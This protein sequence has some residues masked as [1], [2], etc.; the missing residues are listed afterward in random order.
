MGTTTALMQVLSII[1]QEH[2]RWENLI[3]VVSALDGVTDMLLEAAH[4]AQL[5]NRRGYRRIVATLRTRHLALVENLPLANSESGALQ[6][7]IDRLLFDMLD[8]CQTMSD[9]P[10]TSHAAIDQIIGVGERLAARI[11]AVLLRSSNLRGVAVDATDLIITDSVFGNATPSINLTRQRI[12]ENLLPMLTRDIIP[13]VTGF[14]G[15]TEGGQPTTLGRGGSDYTA[16]IIAV[17]VDA[18]EVWMWTDVDGMMSTDPQEI[19]EA[20]TIPELSYDEVAEQA[21]FGARILHARM[22]GP[23][24]E[25][26]VP[27]WV[28]NIFKPRDPGTLIHHIDSDQEHSIKAVATIHG[29]SL[30]SAYSGPLTEIIRLTDEA[31]FT[32][33]GNHAE[34]MISAQSSDRSF[35]C[36]VIPTSAGPEAV[37]TTRSELERRL[38]SRE[39]KT[40]WTVQPVVIIT[41]IGTHI[42]RQSHLT[43][44]IFDVLSGIQ[45]LGLAQGPSNCSLSFV[46]KIE[47]ND[48]ALHRIHNLVINSAGDTD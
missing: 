47:N 33:T 12:K 14:I 7:E 45:I 35:L 16:S 9:Y 41:V 23:L 36:F 1:L 15:A 31:L 19:S 26:R 22:I 40:P 3:V 29:I 21:Y 48:D 2:E 30:I 5:G 11:V 13:V 18:D 8:T 38:T 20:Q 17:C 4:L 44:R 46:L 27:L 10:E 39:S 6:G 37:R 25:Q 24:R 34:V 28:K 43:A 42:D 32:T